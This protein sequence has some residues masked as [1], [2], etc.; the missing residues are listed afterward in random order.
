MVEVLCG[1][2][3][4]GRFGR[5]L[6]NL[7]SDF[8]KTQDISHFFMAI[9]ISDRRFGHVVDGVAQLIHEL[10]SAARADLPLPKF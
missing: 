9:D 5:A 10:K 1:V 2:L 8:D 6:G 3:S 7:Y 4:G